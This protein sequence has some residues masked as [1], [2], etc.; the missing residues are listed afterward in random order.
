MSRPKAHSAAP[1]G[2]ILPQVFRGLSLDLR[3]SQE[4]IQGVWERLAGKEAS[5]HSW[6]RRLGKGRLLIEVE[7]SGWM[8][9]LRLKKEPLLQGLVE[10]L[11]A[12][13]V[14]ELRFRMGERKDA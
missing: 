5:Q 14:K 11:G 3:P 2:D 12:I 7:N 1:L 10:L 4:K 13:C 8:Y 9:A 6:P